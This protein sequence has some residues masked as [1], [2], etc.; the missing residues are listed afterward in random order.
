V[1]YKLTCSLSGGG[2][3]SSSVE[4]SWYGSVPFVQLYIARSYVWTTR[5]AIL[6]WTSNVSPCAIKGG[7]LSLTGLA[8]S[9]STTTTQA[10]T[11]D[12]SYTISCGSG[13]T[14]T[15]QS[16][17]VTYITPSLQFVANATDRLQGRAAQVFVWVTWADSCAPSGGAPQ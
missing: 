9:G 7:S 1:T 3:V 4:I 14:A 2:S 16:Q 6:Q 12:V 11:G 10:T 5:P 15:S 8:S 17:T 13:P